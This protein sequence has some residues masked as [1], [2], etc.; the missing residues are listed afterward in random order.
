MNGHI[1]NLARILR[2]DKHRLEN[3]EQDLLKVT[4][5]AGV[6]K[7]LSEENEKI[8]NDRLSQLG[9][10]RNSRALDVYD[11]LISKIEADDVAI[12]KSLHLEKPDHLESAK[13]VT[14]FV[15]KLHPPKKGYFLKLEKA[16]QFL[17]AQPPKNILKALG[18]KYVEELL[19]K[20]DILEVY[21]ALRFLEGSEWLNG[22]FFKQYE[23]LK[24]DDFEEREVVV[25]AL[26]EKWAKAAEK[27]VAKKYHNVS[28]LKELG[29]IF[30][31]PVFLGISGETLRLLSLLTHYLN[32]VEFYSDLF[33]QIRALGENFAKNIISLLRG[34]VVEEPLS[35]VLPEARRP[36]FLVVQRYLAK[37]DENDWRLFEPR[38]NP[39]ALHWEKAEDEI[40]QIEGK[41]PGFSDDLKFWNGLGTVGGFFKSETGVDILVSFN[42]V[43]TV[44]ALVKRKELMKY[45]YHHQEAIW[46]QIFEFYFSKQALEEHSRKYLLK[47]WFEI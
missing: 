14:D 21:S 37:D 45:L 23:S 31:I 47:G 11:A 42:L 39:E 26:N 20:E 34:D 15:Q 4:G 35:P 43:D 7:K 18:Y 17:I 1:E 5:K 9:L 3:L 38:I 40:Q 36:R 6:L 29:V 41:L 46:N 12:Y 30:V 2:I 22:V 10:S 16:K 13:R 44:M 8:L 33:K 19:Q 24:P 28:H 25:R 32:E 27:F